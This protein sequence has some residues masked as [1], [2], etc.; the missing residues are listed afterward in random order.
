MSRVRSPAPAPVVYSD[1]L[2]QAQAL[3]QAQH[4]GRP[5]AI[6]PREWTRWYVRGLSP[7]EAA[8]EARTLAWNALP[9]AERLRRHIAGR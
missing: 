1:W 8:E 5:Y 4:H 7:E 3:F 2:A 9:A 6:R